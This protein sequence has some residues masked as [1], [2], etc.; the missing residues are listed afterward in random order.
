M[1]LWSLHPKYLDRAGLV[2]LWRE[3]L[4]A[5]AVLQG[6]TRGY[7]HHPQLER[8]RLAPH[9]LACLRAYLSEVAGEARQ[10][11]YAFRLE[12]LGRAVR[13]RA[14][15]IPLTRGQLAYEVRHFLAKVRQRAPEQYRALAGLARW[16]A[17]PIFR[18][19][20]G[21]VAPWEK[22]KP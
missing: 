16:Q 5:Q 7:R 14:K 11:G 3:G 22:V 9:P 20:P 12:K 15:V 1:R 19:T 10:R 6:E 8:F 13:P 18:L 4:L 17:H 21:P 2:A